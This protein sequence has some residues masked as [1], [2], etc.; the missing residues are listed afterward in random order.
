MVSLLSLSLSE[1]LV[2]SV[3]REDEDISSSLLLV[4]L[5]EMVESE[6]SFLFRRFPLLWLS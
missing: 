1:S 6:L 2:L 3:E 4:T 5:V